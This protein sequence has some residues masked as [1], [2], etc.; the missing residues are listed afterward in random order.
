M[1]STK[2]ETSNN[3]TEKTKTEIKEEIKNKE[4]LSVKDVCYLLGASRPTVYR[5]INSGRIKVLKLSTKKTII[6][7]SEIDRLF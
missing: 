4:F 2:I 1:R 6:K 7:R 5:L 3:E